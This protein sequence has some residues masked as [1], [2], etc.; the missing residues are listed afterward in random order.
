MSAIRVL[1]V[2]DEPLVLSSLRRLL[3]REDFQIALAASAAEGLAHL[4]A[5]DVDIVLSD[6]KMPG[7]NG[8]EFLEEV[9]RRWPRP[10]RL[11]LTAQAEPRAVEQ[12]LHDG[13]LHR[14]MTKPWD[15]RELI[16]A[17]RDAYAA[18]AASAPSP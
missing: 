3:G 6:Y 11:M 14:A 2:D 1:L 8:L 12:A 16:Q 13:L 5:H 9:R 15:N 17:L 10:R 18:L 7:M 4:E